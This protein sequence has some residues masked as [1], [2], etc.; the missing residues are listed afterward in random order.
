MRKQ[1]CMYCKAWDIDGDKFNDSDNN[2]ENWRRK[3]CATSPDRKCGDGPS[4]NNGEWPETYGSDWCLDFIE[5][6]VGPED[7]AARLLGTEYLNQ[8]EPST[9]EHI[10]EPVNR[11]VGSVKVEG[12]AS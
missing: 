9:F 4:R 7:R 3:C 10:S 2:P 8:D 1:I 12:D 6:T 11:V 5:R